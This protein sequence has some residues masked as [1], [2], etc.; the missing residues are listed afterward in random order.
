[1]KNERIR[2]K[3][4]KNTGNIGGNEIWKTRT[5]RQKRN[6]G[7]RTEAKGEENKHTIVVFSKQ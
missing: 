7:R 1:M 5:K 6:A 2:Q 4:G 3:Q